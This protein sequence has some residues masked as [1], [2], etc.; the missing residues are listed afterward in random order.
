MAGNPENTQ[1]VQQGI[2]GGGATIA[3]FVVSSVWVPVVGAI[4]AL[5][6]LA[7]TKLFSFGPDPNN[8]PAAQI[9]QTFE[10]AADLI[11]LGLFQGNF[12][13]KATA[14]QYLNAMITALNSSELQAPQEAKDSKPFKDGVAHGTMVINTYVIKTIQQM[15]DSQLV[16]WD[17]TAANARLQAIMSGQIPSKGNLSEIGPGHWYPVSAQQGLAIVQG[18]IAT[19]D[20]QNSYTV[21]GVSVSK[22]KANLGLLAVAGIVAWEVI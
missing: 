14:I 15:P 9:E 7:I 4:A 18:I 6:A 1:I 11:D 21:A 10:Y 5:V 16:T 13:D 3:P 17:A 19:I 20:K 8:V 2:G 22:S 12:I